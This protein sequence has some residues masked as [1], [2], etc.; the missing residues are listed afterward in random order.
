MLSSSFGAI[1]ISSSG[2]QRK[3][4]WTA[5]G[6]FVADSLSS[7]IVGGNLTKKGCCTQ[8]HNFIAQ[9]GQFT[10]GEHAGAFDV[11]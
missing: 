1:F 6:C 9:N 5:G 3:G 2:M 4:G 11:N 10:Q 8:V 7:R